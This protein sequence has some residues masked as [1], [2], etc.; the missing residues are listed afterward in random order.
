MSSKYIPGLGFVA[1]SSS[2][3]I[4]ERNAAFNYYE[5]IAPQYDG[6][7]GFQEGFDD[8]K[9]IAYEGWKKLNRTDDE[10]KNI[11][12]ERE[13]EEW[14]GM[15]GFTD[16]I[17]LEEYFKQIEVLRPL[18]SIEEG[19]RKANISAMENFKADMYDAYDNE[20]GDISDVQSKYGYDEEELSVL[21]GLGAMGKMLFTDTGYMA[22]QI[23]GMVAKDPEM[24]L[25]GLFRIPALAGQ[26]TARATQMA[27]MAM[28]AQPKYVRGLSKAIQSQRGR[29]VI[30]RG[31]EG[32]VYGGVYEALHDLTFKGHID[33]D[34]LERGIA[35]GT[36]LGSA[37]GGVTKNIGKQ[38]WLLNKM[39]SENAAKNIQQLKYSLQDPNLTWQKAEG[40]KGEGVLSFEKGWQQKLADI[41]AKNKGFIYNKTTKTYEP[42]VD[43]TPKPK[44]DA[45]GETIDPNLENVNPD[46]NP[47]RPKKARLPKGLDNETKA[48]FWRDRARYLIDKELEIIGSK[49]QKMYD[50]YILT[51]LTKKQAMARIRNITDKDI[52]ARQKKLLLEKNK[53]GSQKYTKDEAGAIAAKEEAR[54]FEKRNFDFVTKTEKYSDPYKKNWGNRREESLG[55]TLEGAGEVVKT[56]KDFTHKFKETLKDLPKPTGKQYLKAGGIGAATGL[57]IADEDKTYGGL[58]GLTAG[59]AVRKFVKGVNPSQA[60]VRLRMYKVVNESEGISR[61]LQMQAGKTVAI[62]HQVLKGKNPQVSSLEFLTYLENYSKKSKVIDGVDFGAKGRN[63][64][65][66]EIQNAIEAYRDLMKDFEIVAKKLGVFGDRQLQKDYVTHIFKHKKLADGDIANFVKALNSKGSN[67]DNVSTFSNPRK[68]LKNIEELHKS[69]KYPNIETDVFKILDAY[70]RSMS[71]AIAG[72][73]I[74]NQLER[75][76][77]L[78]GRNTFSMII[79]PA[80]MNRKI[81]VPDVGEMTLREYA[82]NK[83]GYKTSNHPALKDKLIHPLMKKS[84]DDF[85]APEIGSEGLVNKLLLVNN[86]MKRVAISFSFFHAQSLV[87]SGI[88]AGMLSEGIAGAFNVTARGKAA[89]KRFNLVRRVAK[90]EFESYGRDANGKPIT[91]TNMH[92]RESSGEVV[93]A[94]LLKEMAEEGVE[95]GVK[96]SEY[97]DAGYNTVKGLMEKYAP[98]LDKAQTF[99]DKWTWDKTHDIG[100]MFTYLTVKD[101]MMSAKPRG[102]AKIMPV[103]S[104]IRG[105]DLGEWKPMSHA[106]A[107]SSAAAYTNDAFGGQRHSKLAMEWQ[108][109]AIENADNPKGFLYNMIALWT[110]PSSAKL[111]NLFLFSPDWT[112]SNL[113]IGF[114]GL[115]MT[116]D[117]VGKVQKGQK[118]TSKEM[119]EW[120]NYMGYLTRGVVATSAVAYIMHDIL[121][122]DDEEFDLADFWLTGRLPLGT[123]EEM[124]VSKQIAEPMHWIMHP[125]QT[126]LNKSSTLPKVGLEMLLGKEYISMKN[127]VL[128]GPQMDRGSPSK[129]AWWLAGKGTPISLSKVKRALEDDKDTYTV[130]DVVKQTMFGTVG[131]PVYG[132]KN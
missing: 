36:L 125:A 25:L 122:D 94:N 55:E 76:A 7:G 14:G 30:G 8:V 22:G 95:I 93:G 69:G 65:E 62:L 89:R 72:K 32:A 41:K 20:D 5:T 75:T 123:G 121:N 96:A 51:G 12:M 131:F 109:K 10:N 18:T 15:V 108:Q 107:K 116:K 74:T 45:T 47:I 87:F 48:N 130:G 23:T 28:R 117:L 102:I 37:F 56:S 127:G 77:M 40:V 85:Y 70:T 29:A 38:S 26:L 91:K 84:I 128:I 3:S 82:I 78:D 21:G 53:D 68:L 80:E 63:K 113:R 111:S 24:L 49:T 79:T 114:R 60:K 101:R 67:L 99:I 66:P 34:N 71:K 110:T 50:D 11:W 57:I 2:K 13:V 115:G 46:F 1:V 90:G 98:P 119:A 86:A 61:T 39:T 103:L 27:T 33:S 42:P 44:T 31:V 88:Y 9:S 97:V 52:L 43:E 132:S 129:M 106:E 81:K 73:N 58:L 120:N 105:K 64:L 92:G 83:L 104:K 118:L 59:L 4:E 112:I 100:K 16:S 124:V 19:D 54:A 126:F 17:A 35:L 6:L